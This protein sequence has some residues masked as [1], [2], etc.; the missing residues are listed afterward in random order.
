M[1][2]LARRADCAPVVVY[3]IFG[4][5]DALVRAALGFCFER[6]TGDAARAA[7]AQDESAPARLSTIVAA[8][9]SRQ[10]GAEEIFET[11]ALATVRRHPEHGRVLRTAL[12]RL[13]KH[14]VRI[15]DDGIRRGELDPAM[16]RHA[17]AWRLIALGI[18][19]GHVAALGLRGAGVRNAGPQ[20][21]ASLLREIQLGSRGGRRHARPE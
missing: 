9:R 6:V 7:A 20:A 21:F 19:R 12:G 18:F 2:N 17:I 3:R 4:N 5:R 1:R 13:A 16:D 11:L 15:L 10:P 8:L 14:L